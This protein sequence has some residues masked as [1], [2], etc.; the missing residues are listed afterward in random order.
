MTLFTVNVVVGA[1]RRSLLIHMGGGPADAGDEGCYVEAG[2]AAAL[3]ESFR[4]ITADILCRI[5][6][7]EPAPEDPTDLYAF[8]R[9][10]GEPSSEER[11]EPMDPADITDAAD[12]ELDLA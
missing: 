5:G 2:N 1:V 7:L 10:P 8:V 12:D 4:K 9:D 6:P 3:Q 11:L